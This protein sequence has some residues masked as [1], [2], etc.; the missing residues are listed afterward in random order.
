MAVMT[1]CYKCEKRYIGCKSYCEPWQEWLAK[2]E[3]EKEKERQVKAKDNIATDFLKQQTH[4][5]R[6]DSRRRSYYKN[7]AGRVTEL[8]E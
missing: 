6:N 8:P 4:R 3:A 7:Y 1:P 5:M 2:H